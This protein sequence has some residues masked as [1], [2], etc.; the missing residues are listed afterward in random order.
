MAKFTECLYEFQNKHLTFNNSN[1]NILIKKETSLTTPAIVIFYDAPFPLEFVN[2]KVLKVCIYE[3][4][5]EE[6][7]NSNKELLEKATDLL[8]Y[9]DDHLESEEK[10]SRR[11]KKIISGYQSKLQEIVTQYSPSHQDS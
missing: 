1:F 11:W 4:P 3:N 10:D 2:G 9:C 5:S 7:I 8:I 6:I